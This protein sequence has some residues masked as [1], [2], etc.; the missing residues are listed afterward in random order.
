VL[1]ESALYWGIVKFEFF[2]LR[3]HFRAG[4]SIAFPPGQAGNIVRGAFGTMLR[5]V[6]CPPE[7]PGA[8]SCPDRATCDYARL[9]EPRAVQGTGPSGLANRPRP[10]VLRAAHLDGKHF[11]AG[12]RFHLDIH[13]FDL[14]HPG[15]ASVTGSFARLANEGLGPDRG[16]V[17]LL[18]ADL[19]GLDDAPVI[20]VSD[21]NTMVLRQTPSPAVIALDP[22]ESHADRIRVHFLTPTELKGGGHHDDPLPFSILFARIRDRLSTLASLYGRGPLPIDFKAMGQRAARVQ[23]TRSELTLQ[24]L[25]RRSSRSGQVHPMGGFTG[26]VEYEGHLAEFL[27]YLAAARWTGVGRHTV[28]GKGQVETTVLPTS[29][30]RGSR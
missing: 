23:I 25:D 14:A 2:R 27:P 7:C 5:A 22:P 1:P 24:R 16:A 28:W 12:G 10:F 15:F 30:P 20:R 29:C 9:F 13:L 26:E 6:A 8:D 19:V 17:E 18:H 11:E 4:E 21:G 3:L